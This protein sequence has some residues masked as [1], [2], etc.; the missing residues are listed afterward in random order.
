MWDVDN[1]TRY[2]HA[3]SWDRDRDGADTWI[4]VIKGTFDILPDGSTRVAAEQLPVSILPQHHGAPGQSSLRLDT[5]L[6]RAK[7]STDIIVSGSAHAPQHR[8]VEQIDVSLR[9]NTFEKTVRVYGD[10]VFKRGI[11]G[12]KPGAPQ[13]FVTIPL[14]YERAFGGADLSGADGERHDWDERNPV[15]VGYA[16]YASHLIG[17]PAPNL[18]YP[19][20]SSAEIPAGFGPVAPHWRPRRGWAGTYDKAW[21]EQR[22]PLL[23]DDLDDRY[24]LSAPHDQQPPTH[25]SGGEPVELRHMTPQGVLR[26]ALPRVVLGFETV[27][28]TGAPVM[29]RQVLHSVIIEPDFPRVCMVWQTSLRCHAKVLKLDQTRVTQKVLVN[30]KQQA[31]G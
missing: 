21:E 12:V 29:H 5:D 30:A 1:Q 31:A 8:P 4:V 2:T 3:H 20:G 23:P 11:V 22:K 18:E 19:P 15:G 9:M 13:P 16:T 14:V 17:K 28:D 6:L 7:P 27:F 25:L 24:F 26:F 10:R